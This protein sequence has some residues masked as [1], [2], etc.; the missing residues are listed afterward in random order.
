MQLKAK[1]TNLKAMLTTASC[2]LLGTAANVSAEESW[3]F[4]TAIMQYAEVDRVSATE[5]IIA[6][7]KTFNNDDLTIHY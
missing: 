7:T 1:K 3:Q 4:D 5:A 2:A 6:G